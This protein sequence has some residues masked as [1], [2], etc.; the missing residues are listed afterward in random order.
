MNWWRKEYQ[1]NNSWT[2]LVFVC[3][4][5]NSPGFCLPHFTSF[6]YFQINIVLRF[7]PSIRF[8]ATV[9]FS[10]LSIFLQYFFLINMLN[11][12]CFVFHIPNQLFIFNNIIFI[13]LHFLKLFR[14]CFKVFKLVLPFWHAGREKFT[15]VP[16]CSNLSNKSKSK[17]KV[18]YYFKFSRSYFI[19][20][21]VCLNQYS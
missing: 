11:S 18:F 8:F 12:P 3:H 16:S 1:T 21:F 7:F 17:F 2:L 14:F 13:I 10:I 20:I 5:L 19:L 9:F 4:I 6:F 15:V